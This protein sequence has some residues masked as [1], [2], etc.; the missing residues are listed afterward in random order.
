MNDYLIS[1]YIDNELDLDEKITFVEQVHADRI[2]TDEALALLRQEKLVR[3]LPEHHLPDALPL[4]DDLPTSVK[5]LWR[6][7]WKPFAGL[8]AAGALASLL[9]VF[10][11]S[12]PDMITESHRFVLYLPDITTVE[13]IGTFTD[14]QP[15]TM[16]P[17]GNSGYWTLT[18][19]IPEGEH[20]YS[21]LIGHERQ[22]ADPTVAIREQD[23]FGGENSILEVRRTAI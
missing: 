2:F 12:R 13:I 15:V 10:L 21:Y 1:L 22:I 6:P 18:M 4:I 7:W 20:R 11:P 17:I 14:W 9:L 19:E 3:T 16:D 23:D 5:T 8:V